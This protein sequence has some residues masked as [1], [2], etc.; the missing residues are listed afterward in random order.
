MSL[1]PPLR[2]TTSVKFKFLVSL[3]FSQ[4]KIIK[5][6]LSPC[7]SDLISIK[8]D[9]LQSNSWYNYQTLEK[10]KKKIFSEMTIIK[11][12]AVFSDIPKSGSIF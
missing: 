2:S 4:K 12:W 10:L 6:D 7:R 3:T 5:I 1:A 11:L 9:Y 8:N